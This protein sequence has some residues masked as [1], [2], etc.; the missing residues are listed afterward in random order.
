MITTRVVGDRID[1]VVKCE[2]R[3]AVYLDQFA[4]HHFSTNREHKARFLGAFA[5]RGEVLFSSANVSEV[6]QTAGATLEATCAFLDA[7]GPYW[8]PIEMDVWAVL[9]ATRRASE[10]HPAL[11]GK[12]LQIV[13]ELTR[14]RSSEIRLGNAL[15]VMRSHFPDGAFFRDTLSKAKARSVRRV[16]ELRQACRDTPEKARVITDRGPVVHTLTAL[17]HAILVEEARSFAWTPNDAVDFGHALMPLVLADAMFMDKA[18][19]R[20]VER[21]AS[22]LPQDLPQIFYEPESSQFLDWL[23]SQ[24]AAG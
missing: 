10:A 18:W 14:G 11:D 23:E 21:I 2:R 24:P 17:V 6:V 19:K 1:V 13:Y 16:A 15:S 3:P 8:V 20:R 7:V 12:L 22:S 4:L 5:S 9:R